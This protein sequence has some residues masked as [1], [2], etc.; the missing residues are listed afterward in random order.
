MGGA[1]SIAPRFRHAWRCGIDRVTVPGA[2]G[3]CGVDRAL[4]LLLQ[5]DGGEPP[6]SPPS[7]AAIP[8]SSATA[9]TVGSFDVQAD[10]VEDDEDGR[11]RQAIEI[12]LRREAPAWGRL[13]WKISALLRLYSQR[14]CDIA[15]IRE[16]PDPS[17]LTGWAV[18]DQI[19]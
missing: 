16:V 2:H 8:S 11:S 10:L 18:E 7:S 13:P 1:K 3:G 17:A 6:A 14:E 12:I 19:G 9:E 15:L 5:N 4:E